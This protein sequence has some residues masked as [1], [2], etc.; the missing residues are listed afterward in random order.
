[1]LA[2]LPFG[3][4]TSLPPDRQG[5]QKVWLPSSIDEEEV[6]PRSEGSSSTT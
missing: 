4:S 1:V 3:R 2:P 6:L 5:R